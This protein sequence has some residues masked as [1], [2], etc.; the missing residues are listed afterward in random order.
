MNT[1]AARPAGKLPA[2][3]TNFVGRRHELAEAR[4]LLS[5][6]RLLTLTGPGGVGKTRLALRL[7]DQ[8]RRAFADG[9]YLVELDM[10]DDPKLL[11]PTVATRLALRDASDDPVATLAEYLEDKRL[12]IVLD[13]CEHLVDACAV[14]A[15]KLLA[16]APGLRVLATSR[17]V[18]GIE[19]EQ[20]LPVP[21]L[22]LPSDD[23]VNAS[24]A[25][26]LFADRAA[27]A[28]PG[29]TI[30][31]RNR[32]RVLQICRRLDGMPLAIEL[33]AVRLRALALDDILDRLSDRFELLVSGS[34]TAPTR[35]RTLGGAIGWSYAL[36]S[37]EEQRVWGR[38]SVFAGPFGLDAAEDVGCGDGIA[39][40]EVFGLVAS[41]VDKS[42][43]TRQENSHGWLARYR[44]LE[45]IRGYGLAQVASAGEERAAHER[46]L[47]HYRRLALRYRQECFGPDQVG[48][49]HKLVSEQANLRVALEFGLTADG[50]AAA[51]MEIATALWS[52][53]FAGGFLREG[54]RWLER[55][56]AANPEPTRARAEALWTCAFL[57][58]QCGGA[59]AG[60]RLL[61]EC[62]ALTERLGDDELTA[63]LVDCAGQAAMLRGDLADASTLLQDAADRHRA[64]GDLYALV[65]TLTA[66]AAVRFFL[67]DPRGADDAAAAL[68]L[69][70]A[71]G[72]AWTR[73]YAL[74]A[75]G[76]HR[77]RTGD[78][79]EG[80][81]LV[82]DA[83]RLQRTL[84]DATGLAYFLELLSWFAAGLGQPERSARLLGAADS[85]W[86]RSGARAFE[87]RTHRT[88][89]TRVAD[90]VRAVIGAEAF[91]A[92]RAQGQALTVDDA[93]AYALD[94]RPGE[95][96]PRAERP[97]APNGLTRRE[98]E[99]AELVAD[100]LTNKE[101]AARLTI[102]QRTAEGHVERVLA[103]LGFTS[104]AQI[105]AWIAA[106]RVAPGD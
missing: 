100:G 37:P 85:A 65:N 41:L 17:Q 57:T 10:L 51:A 16:A 93:I 64:G 13:N 101:I 70:D 44:M 15:D 66:L 31:Q 91:E 21:P 27:A 2:E 73:T 45:T 6:S 76:L 89:D 9:V 35:Q 72:A 54:L 40:D 55:A 25:L 59:E 81:A 88:Q 48:W 61:D 47:E 36:C 92:D 99:I 50:H 104:R 5:S 43:L 30:D 98:R 78:H 3:V 102:A 1:G 53:W 90:Q 96:R 14:L 19:G 49:V 83:V 67:D 95:R 23:A 82:Q 38:L 94:E 42:I 97:A 29:F 33:A 63:H 103:R 86:R 60:R 39:R 56:L 52:F 87:A 69:C 28:L 26:E 22:A 24:D 8:V 77:W 80:A 46:H 106:Q 34:R 84:P 20:I 7:A 18:L 4:R 79:A 68:T 11:A 62:A 105:A 32:D 75:V 71:H 58:V 12:L 74:W